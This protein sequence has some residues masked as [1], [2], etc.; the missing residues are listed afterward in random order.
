M[1]G[2]PANSIEKKR[3]LNLVPGGHVAA[4]LI[5]VILGPLLETYF[6]RA[7]KMSN[8]DILVLF[9]STL[10]SILW[11]AF[12]ASIIVPVALG[13]RRSRMRREQA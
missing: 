2:F 5:G 7:L 8:G 1:A 6:L 9:S 11:P 4:I 3:L 12:A 13:G 10:G